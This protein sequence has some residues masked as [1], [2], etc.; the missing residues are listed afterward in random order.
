M[1]AV[2]ILVLMAS[3]LAHPEEEVKATQTNT[4]SKHKKSET[5]RSK[6]RE[7][8][9]DERANR[10]QVQG[11]R[12]GSLSDLFPSFSTRFTHSSWHTVPMCSLS[13]SR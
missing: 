11:T 1:A 5:R 10:M 13:L 2:L 6:R 3:S 4:F 12:N 9:F 8:A 7:I